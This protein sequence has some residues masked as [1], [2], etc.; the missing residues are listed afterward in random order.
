MPL[1]Q[2]DLKPPFKDIKIVM[3][4]FQICKVCNRFSTVRCVVYKLVLPVASSSNIVS[5]AAKSTL[6]D[7]QEHDLEMLE[8]ARQEIASLTEE[9]KLFLM[10]LNNTL[11]NL[12]VIYILKLY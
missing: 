5:A 1:L 3:E 12:R 10:G 6:A 9:K 8:S 7:R 2:D 4:N 11:A